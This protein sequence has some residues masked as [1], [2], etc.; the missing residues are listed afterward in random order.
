MI[1]LG[2]GEHFGDSLA[3]LL[4]G[5]EGTVRGIGREVAKEGLLFLHRL[6]DE[7]L[8]LGKE[9]VG[10][11]TLVALFLSVVD[12]DVVEVVVAP[13]GGNRGYRGGWI[14]DA[15][16][17]APILRAKGIIRSQVPLPEHSR[18]VARISKIIGHGRVLRAEQGPSAADVDG[19]VTGSIHSGKQLSA[20]GGAH[21]GSMV[22]GKAHA[23][24]M[25]TIQ[26]R[27]L[28]DRVPMHGQF[29]VTLVVGHHDDDVGASP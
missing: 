1:E 12:V 8:G 19:A 27:G 16:L 6:T 11:I 10:A 15:F 9:D 25:E 14:P 24:T 18:G 23:L 26:V 13:V 21:R 4:F 28:E 17:K 2:L 7:T 20:G 5:N 29:R 3:V 22:I